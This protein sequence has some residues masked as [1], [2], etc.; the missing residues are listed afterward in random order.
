MS[1]QERPKESSS[2]NSRS[3][4]RAVECMAGSLVMPCQ[5]A[6]AG[7]GRGAMHRQGLFRDEN[8]VQSNL[9]RATVLLY[10]EPPI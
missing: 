6:K 3:P 8:G 5:G 7:G 4:T 1:R 9:S 2:R 10:N